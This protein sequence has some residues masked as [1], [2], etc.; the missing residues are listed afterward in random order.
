MKNSFYSCTRV[1]PFGSMFQPLLQTLEL[2]LVFFYYG[3]DNILLEEFFATSSLFKIYIWTP[4]RNTNKRDSTLGLLVDVPLL[5]FFVAESST[6]WPKKYTQNL[7]S[8]GCK[9]PRNFEGDIIY[10][11]PKD[12]VN[13]F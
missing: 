11:A 13:V 8:M 5:P 1:S 2:R 12:N 7:H 10:I 9:Q 3:R 4:Q 6:R